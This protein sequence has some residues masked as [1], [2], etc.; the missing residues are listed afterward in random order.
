MLHPHYAT[1]QTQQCK[2]DN[3]VEE[4]TYLHIGIC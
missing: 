4:D 1:R 2:D 3:K